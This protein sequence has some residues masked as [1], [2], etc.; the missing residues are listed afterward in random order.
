[1]PWDPA[2]GPFPGGR[3]KKGESLTDLIQ[4]A[5]DEKVDCYYGDGRYEKVERRKIWA[6]HIVDMAVYGE[7]ELPTRTEGE[8]NRVLKFNADS[9]AKHS[10]KTLRYLEPPE[11]EIFNPG[12]I[13]NI[14][15]D[16]PVPQREEPTS[17]TQQ[18][19]LTLQEPESTREP[20]E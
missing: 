1:L 3:P 16:I 11:Q 5:L 17:T 6:R 10:I 9:Y 15:F 20:E 13:T 18:V 14:I 19:I 2:W 12:G 8:K 7:V 4:A